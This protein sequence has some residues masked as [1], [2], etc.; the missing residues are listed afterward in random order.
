MSIIGEITKS[1]NYGIFK[2]INN[3]LTLEKIFVK[4]L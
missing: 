3:N 2:I 4:T 1:I